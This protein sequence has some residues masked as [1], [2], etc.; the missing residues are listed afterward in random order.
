MKVDELDGSL[1][2]FFEQLKEHILQ[3]ENPQNYEFTQREIRQA[4][5]LSKSAQYTGF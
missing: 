3:K 5:N 4:L 2:Q 1:R